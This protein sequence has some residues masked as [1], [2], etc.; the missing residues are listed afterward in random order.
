VTLFVVTQPQHGV[1]RHPQP[2][3]VLLVRQSRHLVAEV[4]RLVAEARAAGAREMFVVVPSEETGDIVHR[5][6]G[7]AARVVVPGL[8]SG[9]ATAVREALSEASAT[10]ILVLGQAD[11]T[12]RLRSRREIDRLE[13]DRG[14]TTL[15]LAG[16]HRGT[17]TVRELARR[18]GASGRTEAPI[19]FPSQQVRRSRRNRAGA[20]SESP[21]A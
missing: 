19:G 11:I 6:V 7:A 5:E 16:L 2:S 18:V 14:A 9:Q 1:N 4:R 21:A 17:V 12:R 20:A 8:L 15:L 10:P 13:L 3:A